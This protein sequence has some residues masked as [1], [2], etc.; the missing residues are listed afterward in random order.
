MRTLLVALLLTLMA[1]AEEPRSRLIWAELLQQ[2]KV[3]LATNSKDIARVQKI[4]QRLVAA[5]QR[6]VRWDFFVIE[7]AGPNAF[8]LGEGV[9]VV[10]DGLLAVGL[11]DDELAGVLAHEVAHGTEQHLESKD[12]RDEQRIALLKEIIVLSRSLDKA[13]AEMARYSPGSDR[14]ERAKEAYERLAW[15]TQQRISDLEKRAAFL[16]GQTRYARTFNHEQEI[17][18]DVIGMR[19]AQAAGYK[20]DGLGRALDK[21]HASAAKTFGRPVSSEGFTHPSLERRQQVL[22][23]VMTTVK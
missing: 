8:T 3:K 7:D 13:E 19:Y 9:I 17:D 22:Q 12:M 1:A 14:H 18:A 15:R 21:L 10:S 4:G 23:K 20:A 11:D 16:D 6:R 2:G 5:S